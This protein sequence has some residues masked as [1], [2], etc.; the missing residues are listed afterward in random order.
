MVEGS[1]VRAGRKEAKQAER[2]SC[3]HGGEGRRKM[4][5]EKHLKEVGQN[6][7]GDKG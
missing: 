6:K 3:R 4:E 2:Q 5:K 1:E 7:T